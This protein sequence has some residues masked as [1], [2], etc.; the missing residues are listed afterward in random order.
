[1]RDANPS[2]GRRTQ[3][4]RARSGAA[5]TPAPDGLL[6]YR[7]P[8][9]IAASP[10]ILAPLFVTALASCAAPLGEAGP[11][12]PPE[13]GAPCEQ[14]RTCIA[15]RCR[16][17]DAPPAPADTLRVV[18]AP[19]D[20][21]VVAS[22]GSGGG[23]DLLPDTVALGRAAGGTVVMLFRFAATWRDDAEV[24][25]AFLVLDLVDAAPPADRP[26]TFEAARIV[27]PW[28]PDVVS[29]GRQPRLGVPV[30]AGSVRARHAAPVRVDVT[31]LVRDWSKRA[32]DDHGIALL[33]KGDDAYGAPVY[34]GVARGLGPRLEVYVK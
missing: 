6:C 24:A 17:Q 15:G 4:G 27:E 22:R 3:Q 30:Q 23:G 21:A 12:P 9:V 1:M 18:I 19:T 11:C 29:W 8:V 33:A 14:G 31:P 16:P 10:R 26:I 34:V 13:G 28:R 32:P 7:A 25:S 20:V 5:R 2:A